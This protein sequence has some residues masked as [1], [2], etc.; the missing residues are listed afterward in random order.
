M[1]WELSK[2][3]RMWNIM[4][5]LVC[6]GAMCTC[7]FGTTPGNLIVSSQATVLTGKPVATIMD[8]NVTPFGM[9]QSLANPQ[10]ASATSAAMGVLT[11]MPCQPMITTWTTSSMS[12]MV[13][14]KPVLNQSSKGMCAYA[15]IVQ[16]TQPG[17][18]TVQVP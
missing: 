17:Q 12:V 1:N 5:A 15:G 14:N 9:C 18:M 8:T 13:A 3:E 7:S 6:M 11:P 10:V 2:L 4:P 16:I